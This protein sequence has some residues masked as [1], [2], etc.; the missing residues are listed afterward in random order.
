MCKIAHHVIM[1]AALQHQ[2]SALKKG[3]SPFSNKEL[4]SWGLGYFLC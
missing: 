3:C 2:Y 4:S 1:H